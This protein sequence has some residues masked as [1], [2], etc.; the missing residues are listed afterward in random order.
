MASRFK[1]FG[2]NIERAGTVPN[3]PEEQPRSFAPPLNDDGALVIQSGAYYGTYVDLDGLVKNEQEL[4]TRYLEMSMQPECEAAVDDI[5]NE[6]IVHDDEGKT[7]SLV[8]DQ[9][10]GLDDDIKEKIRVE[11]SNVLRLMNFS[12]QGQ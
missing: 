9:V 10:D 1:L 6:A 8:L 3:A 7:V 2:W 5:T 12:N 11:F 4:I